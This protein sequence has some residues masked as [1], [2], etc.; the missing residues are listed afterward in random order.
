LGTACKGLD[1]EKV[2]NPVG[3]EIESGK[4]ASE[5]WGG[6]G[7]VS[8]HDIGGAAILIGDLDQTELSDVSGKGGLGDI[9]TA[10]GEEFP[11]NF[12]GRNPVLPNDVEDFGVS[13]ELQHRGGSGRRPGST[14]GGSG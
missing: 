7:N 11:Q 13:L 5:S 12:L 8:G 6:I 14:S 3:A 9:D 4:E 10:R 2:L 1:E